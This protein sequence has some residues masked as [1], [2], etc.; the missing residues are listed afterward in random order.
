[1][2]PTQIDWTQFLKNGTEFIDS[3]VEFVQSLETVSDD[4]NSNV[5]SDVIQSVIDV[6]TGARGLETLDDIAT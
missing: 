2:S 1:M 4:A 3:V 6:L 5:I